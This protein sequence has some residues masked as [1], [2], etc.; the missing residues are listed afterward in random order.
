MVRASGWFESTPRPDDVPAGRKP[1]SRPP[2][3]VRDR[4]HASLPTYSGPYSVSTVLPSKTGLRTYKGWNNGHRSPRQRTS[5]L[6]THQ[7]PPQTCSR[8]RNRPHVSLL[9]LPIRLWQR[10]RPR[11]KQA[12][13]SSNLAAPTKG[14]HCSCL[15]K[16]CGAT[17]V[18]DDAL[19]LDD[20]R[21][22]KNSSFQKR[23]VSDALAA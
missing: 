11:R 22:H 15:R 2:H 10:S 7:T 20:D 5:Y 16:I 1:K 13:V 6:L 8:S 21:F 18:V 12:M 23:E 19:V 9:S 14:K 3:S 17:R 4:V